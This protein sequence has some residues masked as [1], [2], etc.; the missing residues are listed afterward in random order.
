MQGAPT[1]PRI[2]NQFKGKVTKHVGFPLWQKSYI[3]RVIRN[4]NGYRRVWEYIENN[5][6]NIDYADDHLDFSEM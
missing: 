5:P 2:I 4:E 6:V 3:D 1:V